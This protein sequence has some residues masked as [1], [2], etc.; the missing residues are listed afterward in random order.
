M[1]QNFH[2]DRQN[3]IC[4]LWDDI[5][6]YST[7]PYQ[8]YAY[9]I[10]PQ[11]KHQTI[12]GLKVKKVKSWSKE[13]EKHGLIFEHDVPVATRVLIDKYYESDE[14]SVNHRILIFDIEVEKAGKHSTPKDAANRITSVA[15]YFNGEYTCLLLDETG[16]IQNN[17]V[18]ELTIS[19]NLVKTQIKTFSNERALLVQF[20]KDWRNINPTIVTAWNGETYDIPYLYNRLV[21]VLGYDAANKLSP[22]G[23]V[24]LKELNKR[25]ITYK[26]AGVS[27]LDYMMMYKKFTYNEEPSYAL[28]YIAKKELKRGKYSYEGT[29]DDLYKNDINGFIEYNVTDVELIVALEKKK[30]LIKTTM[31][32]C[33]TGH[34]P[35][36]E[37]VFSSR[38]LE[39]ASLTYCK[40]NNLISFRTSKV[41]GESDESAEGALVK[42]PTPGVFKYVIDLDL[43]SLYP[44]LIRTL[45]ISPETIFGKVQNWNEDGWIAKVDKQYEVS[46]E[47]T[48]A[49]NLAGNAQPN[50]F[51][52][53]DDFWK[54]ITDN[55]LAIASNGM[56]FKKD[57]PGLIP[58]ILTHW[59]NERKRLSKLAEEYGLQGNHEQYEYYDHK[60]LVQK[61]MLNTFYGVLLLPSFRFYNRDA[62]ESITLTGQSVITFSMRVANM[63]CNSL[64][65]ST[66]KDYIIASD[67]DSIFL[68]AYQFIENADSLTQDE[69]VTNTLTFAGNLQ[70]YINEK[71]NM[72]ALNLHNA[73]THYLSIKQ[74]MIA[75]RGF[76][77][78]AKKRY[79]LW[80]IN[81]K[82]VPVDELEIKGLDV[83]RSSFPKIFR[84][85]MKGTL[86]DILHDT[87]IE[88]LN[89]RVR[90]FKKTIKQCSLFDVMKASTVK[91]L[92]KYEHKTK[93]IPIHIKSAQNYNKLLR[94]HKIEN[95]PAI[96]DGDKILYVYLTKN[97]FGF[98]SIAL[99]G[100]GE[101]PD[102]IVK[103]AERYVDRDLE[104][105]VT[106]LS[107]LETIWFDL[108]WGKVELANSKANDFF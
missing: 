93:A 2:Y 68:S 94:L 106:Y 32:I 15:Y 14:P 42:S 45:N 6:G 22:I 26:I 101:D 61:I 102:D 100:Q 40:R 63:F 66:G 74:E 80:I 35:Y 9:Q 85:E 23:V 36:E 28:D 12:N 92:S 70:T 4:H 44:S 19:G 59:F 55:N 16:L 34:V 99:K 29:L 25:D 76:F 53:R 18:K 86:H 13:A 5:N 84:H 60:Q 103:F 46:F 3:G 64:L 11:G 58:S 27:F 91:E 38:Y 33:H 51:I 49:D 50:K 88:Q 104:F 56:L 72:Y 105:Q 21:N 57:K 89:Q 1:Y 97:P 107:K 39:G 90:D 67:T 96:T 7:F 69:L 87:P 108:G 10:D 65:N 8:Q 82:G 77:L 73:E 47:V 20:L 75:L 81:K 71:Y 98:E 78:N 17:T 95:I 54:F 41:E 43:T 31:G 83:V 37:Y 62:G 48:L 52:Q 30:T 24:T 79:A